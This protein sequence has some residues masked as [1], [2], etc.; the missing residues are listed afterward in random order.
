[1]PQTHEH[2]DRH[3]GETADPTP[4][5]VQRHWGWIVPGLALSVFGLVFVCIE[6]LSEL[7]K[8]TTPA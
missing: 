5:F 3:Q 1:M 6:L 7:T 4:T 8:L 2:P